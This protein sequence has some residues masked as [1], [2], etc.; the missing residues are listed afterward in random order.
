MC[1][2][3]LRHIIHGV[4]Y[5]HTFIYTRKQFTLCIVVCRW[6]G[7]REDLRIRRVSVSNKGVG[8]MR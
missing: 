1:V 6:N 7:W 4:L 3:Q 8:L 5:V 2:S